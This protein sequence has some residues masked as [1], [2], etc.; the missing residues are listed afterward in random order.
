MRDLSIAY[1]NSC[2]AKTWSNKTTVR[3]TETVQEY[4]KLPKAERDRAKDKGGYVGGQL[5]GNRR[6]REN[7]ISRSMLT[8]DVD[9][10]EADFINKFYD[11]CK[12][13][14]AVYTTH[15]HTSEA[16]RVRIIIP[17]TRDVTSDEY[18]AIARYFAQEWGIDQFDECSYRPHQLMY[19]PTTPSNGEY[20]FKRIDGEWLDPD[21]FLAAHPDWKDCSLLPTSSRESVVKNYD[22]KKQEDPLTKEG[23]VGA[24]CRA[25]S[26][27][28]AI[29]TF[30]SDVYATTEIPNRYDFMDSDSMPGVQ[31]YDDKFSYSHHASDPAC[32][33]LLNAFDLVRLHKF[34]NDDEKKSFKAMCEFAMN[35]DKVKLLITNERL[36]EAEEDFF[37]SGDDWKT[38]LKYQP[39]SQV[40]E[41][42]VYNLNLIL[43]NDP[44]FANFAY[45]E[46]ANRI[47][48][49]GPLPWERPD[50]NRFWRDA[51]TAQLKSIMDIRY[52]PFSSRNHDV[53]FTKVADD[54]SFHPIRDYLDSLPAWDGVKRV[55]DVF[56]RYLKAD[57]TEYIR[58][59]TR[60]TFAAAVAR[61]YV[62]GIKFDCV[63]V[64]DGDQG[65]GKSTIVKDLVTA[66]YYSETLSLTDMDDKSGAEK[67]QGFWVVEIG[68]LAGMRKADIEKVKAFLSTSDDK[69]RPSYGKVVESHPRQC[70][71]IATVNGERGYLRDI[72]GNRRFWIIKVHQK[73]QKK[74]W[75]FTEE[76]RQQFWA[77]AKEIWKSGEK[78]YLEGDVLE[79]AEKAQKGAMEADERVGMVEEY[80]NTR[81]PDDWDSMDLYARRN[82]L[83]GSEF[84]N[85]VHTGSIVRTEVSNAE[86]WCECFGKSL[87]E[88]KASDSYSIAAMMS[89][90]PGW[91]RTTNI[92]RQPI[93]G[94]Q[95]LYHYGG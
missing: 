14:A 94:R 87:Q 69:Y 29:D 61:I 16:P 77:E 95:R 64:L 65:I 75:N 4:P 42:S 53:A 30:L 70:I 88:L 24:F 40:L 26:I 78:L 13:A 2:M 22:G 39:R 63:P 33:Q 28:D 34:G 41:N 15:G 83:S 50:A 90:I 68:E 86:I 85:P 74:T 93:Y 46:L 62:P 1:G 51:D 66:D 45:N 91:E 60:K 72:T 6:K 82:Y 19:W 54:R 48:V 80:L 10:A 36:A 52:L 81:L 76:Y 49:T 59:V 9:N 38:R 84:G 71:V 12:Y 20:I 55:E 18:V 43:N 27:T 57:D 79:E 17:M 3:T 47:Q 67:L 25:Y 92:K 8:C 11:E 56:I 89:Q 32:G 37:A 58:T 21:I 5:R 44:D 23:V 31:I 7:V 35:D 73:K